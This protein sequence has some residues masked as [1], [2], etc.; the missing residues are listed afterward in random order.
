MAEVKNNYISKYSGDQLD[1]AIAAL[2][3]LDK[4][5]ITT[6]QFTDFKTQFDSK[7][8]DFSIEISKALPIAYERIT[9]DTKSNNG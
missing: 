7:M 9:D 1:A 6:K 8:S 3:S 5:F 4:L 2:G